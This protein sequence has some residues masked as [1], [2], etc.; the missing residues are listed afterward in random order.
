VDSE[1]TTVEEIVRELEVSK[2]GER[3][4]RAQDKEEA[5]TMQKLRAMGYM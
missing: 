1:A 3:E 5:N 2:I 4:G